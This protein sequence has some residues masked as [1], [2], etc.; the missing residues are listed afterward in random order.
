MNWK[1]EILNPYLGAIL[2]AVLWPIGRMRLP[3][4]QGSITLAGLVD[5]VEVLRDRWGI[6]HIFANH[7]TDMVFAQGFV[8]AQERL[9][10]MDF[11]RRV[12]FGRLSEVL[13]E[14]ALPV[15]R[16]MRTLGFYRTAE[17]E[18]EIVSPEFRSFLE[19]YCA[20]VNAWM[21]SA[22]NRNKLPIEFMLLGYRPEPWRVADS[23]GWGKLMCWTLAANWQS[24]LYR[25]LLHK[26][27]GNAKTDEL[28]LNIEK[29]RAVILDAVS[30]RPDGMSF[31]PSSIFTGSTAGGG[32]GSNN[33]VVDGKRSASGSPLL[34]NDMHLELTAPG[35]WFENHLVGGRFNIAGVVMPGV[36]LIIAG[37]NRR[38]AW[39]YTDSFADTQDLYEEHIRQGKD[40]RSEYEFKGK[41]L[42]LESRPERIKIK[43]GKTVEEEVRLT[44]HGP[45]INSFFKD[46]F[47]DLPPMALRWTALEPAHTFEAVYEMNLAEDC[48]S[49]REALRKFDDPSQN[50]VYADTKGNIAYTLNGRIPIRVKGDGSIPSPG[51]TGDQEW[52]GYIPFEELP[53]LFNPGS[54]FIATANNQVQ[55]SDFPHFIGKDYVIS[56]RAG[57]IVELLK[58]DEKV[59]IPY[60]KKMQF[61]L[62]SPSGRHFA[63]HVKT[64]KTSDPELIPI[65]K[66]MADWNGELGP[67][68]PVASVFE[69]TIRL[70]V[71]MLV[72]HHLGAFGLRVRGDGPFAGEW[73]GHIWEWFVNLLDEPDSPF[74]DIGHG[75]KR[76]DILILALRE[77][78]D[79][80]KGEIGTDLSNWQWKKIHKLFFNHILG[81]QEPL[82]QVFNLGPFPIGGDGSTIWASH[83]N[84][85]DLKINPIV[86]P[87]FRFIADLGDLDHCQGILAPGQS[88]HFSSPHYKDGIKPWFSGDYHLILIQ[89]SEIEENLES[90]LHLNPQRT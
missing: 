45:I 25:G 18:A 73:P 31:D 54:G 62:I 28:E 21:D 44:H 2:K 12:V 10:Q 3:Q 67:D 84:Y 88:G 6:A 86:G 55:R 61:D 9:W 26:H 5:T 71:R 11:T 16:V 47:P 75:E 52:T 13:G 20:G 85:H 64:L 4:V 90:K 53:Q 23:M 7:E 72:N 8:H 66:A 70:S 14:A 30:I 79:F 77:A 57:R 56:D 58:T 65:V 22:I 1:Q 68:N 35:I 83:M 33:W 43:G 42:P 49:F 80:L 48:F 29:A 63:D 78:V 24:E 17:K 89:R 50:I 34:A 59:D 37:H 82:D 51:W 40:G 15:D 76:D 69:V 19:S 46:A 32:V 60:Y 81:G 39:A 36:P 74:F 87:P 41:W 27:L 38:V